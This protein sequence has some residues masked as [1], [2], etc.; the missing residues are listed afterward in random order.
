M[1]LPIRLT[2]NLQME[3]K[4]KY[5]IIALFGSGVVCIIFA[6]IRLILLGVEGGRPVMVG[7]SKSPIRRSPGH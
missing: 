1:V 5:G 3:R 2:W 4:Q 6:T 7:Y